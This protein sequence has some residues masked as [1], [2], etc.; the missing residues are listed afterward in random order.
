MAELSVRYATALFELSTESG[1]LN[2]YLEQAVFLR[3]T[4]KT[5]ECRGIIEHPQVST[6]EKCE[7]FKNAFAGKIQNDLLAFLYLAVSKGREKYLVPAL[8]AFIDMG[9]SYNGEIT[10]QVVSAVELNEKQVSALKAMLSKKLGKQ[11]D[12]SVKVDSSIIGG[13]SIY[14]DGYFMDHT[15]KRQLS[16]LEAS[17]KRSVPDDS[18]A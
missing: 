4:L 11:V 1:L 17:I 8:T 13:L 3:D 5:D 9:N 12:V 14:A 10:A 6:A 18:Q 7:F 15:V 16:D 2:E